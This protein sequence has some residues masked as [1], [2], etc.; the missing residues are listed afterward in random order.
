MKLLDAHQ[1]VKLST[2]RRNPYFDD[3]S[4]EMLKE[5]SGHMQLRVYERGEILF[6]EVLLVVV[7]ACRSLLKF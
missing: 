5:I 2:L 4:E 7:V 1:K 6:W 3:L